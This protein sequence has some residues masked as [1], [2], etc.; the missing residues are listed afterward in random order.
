MDNDCEDR[1]RAS[2]FNLQSVILGELLIVNLSL[3]EWEWH[4]KLSRIHWYILLTQAVQAKTMD[5][6]T[7]SYVAGLASHFPP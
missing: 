2:P 1:F 4:S 5:V 3:T 6:Y 7:Y